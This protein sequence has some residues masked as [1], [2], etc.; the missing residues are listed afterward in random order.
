MSTIHLRPGMPDD[1]PTILRFIRELAEYEKLSHA[2]VATED[3][4]REHLFGQRAYAETLI[5]ELNGGAVGYALYFHNFS[6][7]EG[8]PG[9][10]IEDI[11]VQPDC[12]GH[13]LGK[14]LL[15]RVAA[16]AAERGCARLEW[17]V[18]DWNEP[19]RAFYRSLGAEAMGEW[20]LKRVDGESL[21]ALA[22]LGAD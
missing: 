17:A 2:V 12:R 16:I 10:Y 9:I 19:A 18:L 7:F 11:Y 5:G 13:G 15:T 6:T 20:V 22:R 3:L 21:Q 8:R 14:A 4:L 1:V